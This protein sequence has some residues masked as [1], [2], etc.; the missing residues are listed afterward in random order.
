MLPTSLRRL[1]RTCVTRRR[2]LVVGIA[3]CLFLYVYVDSL[4][5]PDRYLPASPQLSALELKA[6][7]W[8]DLENDGVYFKPRHTV[9][10]PLPRLV[11]TPTTPC[12][13]TSFIV[14]MVPS[15][16]K[17]SRRRELIRNTWAAAVR[18]GQWPGSEGELGVTM[19]VVFVLGLTTA[20]EN[21]QVARFFRF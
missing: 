3:L 1:Q 20:K 18:S 17:D 6:L 10:S 21:G 5:S 11:I 2:E 9:V 8:L 7:S 14:A 12:S 4:L 15:P 16:P 13:K 19:D